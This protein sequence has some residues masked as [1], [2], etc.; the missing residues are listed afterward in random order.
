MTKHPMSIA[1][2]THDPI[3]DAANA[4]ADLLNA[5]NIDEGDHTA[6]TP[7]R[8]AKAWADRLA[9]YQE[10]PRD[11]LKVT[12]TAP[13]SPGLVVA[14]NVRIQTTCAHHLL[15]I[16]GTATIAYKP[17]PGS[18]VVGLSKLNRL[19]EGYARR[20]QVQENL[21]NQIVDAIW[22]ILK[23]EWVACSI[24]ADHGCMTLRGVRDTCSDTR[25]WKERGTATEG[26]LRAF[27][28]D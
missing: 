21:T 4:V 7:L 13:E 3:S 18:N 28:A 12:F 26:D 15:P 24:I 27:W 25:T 1:F 6:N 19:A 10:E 9:G 22:E 23:P 20:L 11:H 2:T 16:T 5:F 17:R 8:V 14:R